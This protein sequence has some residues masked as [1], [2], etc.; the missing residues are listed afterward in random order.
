MMKSSIVLFS[1][2]CILCSLDSHAQFR[3]GPNRMV[4]DNLVDITYGGTGL[5]LSANYSRVLLLQRNFFASASMGVGSV[6]GAGG[7]S[8]PHQFTVNFGK[9]RDFFETGIGGSFWAG[10]SNSSGVNESIFSYNISPVAGYRRYI[11]D[12]F[13]LRIYASPLF[14]VA[15]EIF[16]GEYKILP[17]GGIC[18]GYTF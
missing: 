4:K 6:L 8:L 13:V 16:F 7:L 1:F 11:Y 15:G 14:H 18:L 3:P 12:D 9:S 2:F 10:K 17:Y 5:F